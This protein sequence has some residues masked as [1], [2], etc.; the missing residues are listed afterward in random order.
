MS[1]NWKDMQLLLCKV[2][3]FLSLNKNSWGHWSYFCLCIAN[4][5]MLSIQDLRKKEFYDTTQKFFF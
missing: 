1:M 4:Y 3:F 2:V 5:C